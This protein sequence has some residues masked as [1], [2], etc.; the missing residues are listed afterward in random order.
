MLFLLSITLTEDILRLVPEK[1]LGWQR[2]SKI[3]RYSSEGIYSYMDG[4]GE[5]YL[6]YG[7]KELTVMRYKKPNEPEIL[8]EIFDMGSSESAFGVFTHIQGRSE[9]V[10]VGNDSEYKDGLLCFW[11]HKFFV[12]IRAERETISSKSAV[13][14]LGKAISSS[15]R[16]E[17][18]R[19]LLLYYLLEDGLKRKTIRYT[20]SHDI[21]NHH[22][23]ISDENILG[24][25]PKTSALIAEYE[26]GA[27]ILIVRYPKSSL[28]EKAYKRFMNLYIKATTKKSVIKTENNRWTAISLKGNFLIVVF[29]A[30]TEEAAFSKINALRKKIT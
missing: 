21:L 22:Y 7:F 29:D 5:V 11:R 24:L 4:A 18:R 15:I 23:F 6:A 3:E 28:A 20:F 9:D 19:P 14:S 13:F 27:H 25:S 1:V 16:E 17:G 26:D 30:H 8:V 10:G 12:C 2:E